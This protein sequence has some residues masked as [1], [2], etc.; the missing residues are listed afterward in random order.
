MKVPLDSM[1]T[2]ESVSTDCVAYHNLNVNVA[3]FPELFN[4]TE[5]IFRVFLKRYDM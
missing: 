1:L 2:T 5:C 3:V 4:F